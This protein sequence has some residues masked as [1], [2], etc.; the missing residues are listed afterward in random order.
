VPQD[1]TSITPPKMPP[2]FPE[3]LTFTRSCNDPSKRFP[4][5][6]PATGKPITTIQAGNV[7]TTLEAIEA[8]KVAFEDWRW[9]NPSE[10]GALL[11]RCADELAKHREILAELLCLENGK[12][13]Q[14]A[15]NGDVAFLIAIF[16]YFGSLVDKLPTQFYDKGNVL[17]TVVR[18]PLGVCA[19]ILPFNWPPIHAG[20][21]LAPAIACGNTMILKPGEQAPLTAIRIVEILQTV[22]PPNVV[23]AV[24]GLG[25]EVPQALVSHPAVKMVSFTG[26]TAAGS[27]VSKTAAD[28]VIPVLLE[29]GGKNAFIIFEDADLDSAIPTALEGAF[30]NKGEACTAASRILIHRSLHDQFVERLGAA[31]KKLVVGNGMNPATHVGP[32]VSRSQQQKVLEYI[33]IGQEEGAEIVAQ[34]PLPKDPE[35]KDGFFVAPTLFKGVK[36]NMRIAQEE[37]FGPVVTV[38]TFETEDEAISITNQSAYGLTA[39]VYTRD[40]ERSNRVSRKLDVGMGTYFEFPFNG[41]SI[42]GLALCGLESSYRY[43]IKYTN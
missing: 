35:C 6:N 38:T 34:A 5:E 10:R 30:F 3:L 43:S 20:G 1:Q 27:A 40:M 36:R 24:P 9:R 7:S 11:L 28:T 4:V 17:C 29:L 21:K 25:P 16:Q 18:E 26:S 13:Y 14:D 2:H 32:C 23:Q 39:C 37:M 41:I 8:A 22:L 42:F 15:L 19:G 12:P 33:R 31:V